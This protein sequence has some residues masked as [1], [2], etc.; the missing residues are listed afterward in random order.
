MKTIPSVLLSGCQLLGNRQGTRADAVF[1]QRPR[2][3]RAFGELMSTVQWEGG[4]GKANTE[5]FICIFHSFY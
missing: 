3:T 1:N 2:L 5:S 4:L